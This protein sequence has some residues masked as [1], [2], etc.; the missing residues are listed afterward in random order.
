MSKGNTQYDVVFHDRNVTPSKTYMCC[1]ECGDMRS[2]VTHT[3]AAQY[4]QWKGVGRIRTC[5]S[6][7]HEYR[8]LELVFN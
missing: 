5:H 8:T 3:S 2:R 6:C 7:E 1:P 4:G